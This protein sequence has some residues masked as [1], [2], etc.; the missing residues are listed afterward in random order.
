MRSTASWH[1]L[2][3]DCAKKASDVAAH[4]LKILVALLIPGHGSLWTTGTSLRCQSKPM[5]TKDDSTA[6]RYAAV[7]IPDR[8]NTSVNRSTS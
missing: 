4:L 2:L 7:A 5:A 8:E 3:P 6:R 1:G